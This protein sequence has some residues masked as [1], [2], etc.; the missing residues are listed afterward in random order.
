MLSQQL[1]PYLGLLPHLSSLLLW[2]S[3]FGQIGHLQAQITLHPG[4]VTTRKAS[5]KTGP[6]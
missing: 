6:T 2:S 3:L 4:L 1:K 5:A